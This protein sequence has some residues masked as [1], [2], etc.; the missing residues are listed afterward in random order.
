M[1]KAQLQTLLNSL[2]PK[3]YSFAYALVPDELQA[4]QMVIDA[5]AVFLVREKKFI[6]EF[7]Y[8]GDKKEK[9]ILKKFL[10]AHMVGELYKM[11]LKRSSQLRILTQ[12]DH[13]QYSSFYQL[14]TNQRAILFLKESFKYSIEGIQEILGLQKY[15]VIETLY[16]GRHS[17]LEVNDSP[18]I[19]SRGFRSV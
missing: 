6:T 16:N 4:E 12:R 11:G 1:K 18:V 3:F 10:M 8:T 15:Q 14:K 17:I 13:G 2:I 7:K 9:S 19:E 5:Y